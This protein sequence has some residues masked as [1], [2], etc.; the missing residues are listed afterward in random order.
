MTRTLCAN[1]T[2]GKTQNDLDR[3]FT[4]YEGL[5]LSRLCSFLRAREPDFNVGHAIMIY[6]LN[7]ADV[8][9]A[10]EGPPVELLPE[11]GPDVKACLGIR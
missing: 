2:A 3:I 1:C 6:R 11:C 10:T 4:L 8:D 9:Q 7:Q 5:R